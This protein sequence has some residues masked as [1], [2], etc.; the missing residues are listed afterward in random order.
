MKRLRSKLGITARAGCCL[1]VLLVTS[2][3]AIHSHGPVNALG[4]KPLRSGEHCVLCMAAHL[5]LAVS[6]STAAPVPVFTAAA[7][8]PSFHME[9]AR[10]PLSAFSLYMRPP[11]GK[12]S[13]VSSEL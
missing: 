4:A 13:V 2:L 6:A 8:L 1:L 3:D 5:P 11:P 7:M 12:L 10:E 9:P